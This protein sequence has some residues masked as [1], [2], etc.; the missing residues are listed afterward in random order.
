MAIDSSIP[1]ADLTYQVIGRAMSVHNELGP[2]LKEIMYHRALSN[3][4][5]DAGLEYE[6]EK[7]VIVEMDGKVV[8]RLY[9]DHLVEGK[10]V[11]EEKALPHLITNDE[12]AQV[13]TY[14]AATELPVGLLLNFGRQRLNYKRILPPKTRDQWK[15]NARRFTKAGAR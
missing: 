10:I 8:G 15:S 1:H 4:L 2:G 13:V 11:V 6:A 14:L 3:S 7:P 9:L 12:V 5:S